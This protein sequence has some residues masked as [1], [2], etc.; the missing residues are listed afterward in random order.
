MFVTS[1]SLRRD[2]YYGGNYGKADPSQ[3][4]RA[5]IEV[6]GKQGKVELE[7]DPAMSDRI[8][9]IIADEV[10]AAGDRDHE[11]RVR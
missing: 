10:A 6:H 3:S 1:I 4:F 9:A 8:I 7:L 11:G 2:G 5:T